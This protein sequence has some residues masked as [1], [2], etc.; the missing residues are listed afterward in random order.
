MQELLG[1]TIEDKAV[2]QMYLWTIDTMG[3]IISINCSKVPEAE[4]ESFKEAQWK[5]NVLPRLM[6]YEQ[7]VKGTS[8]FLGYLSIIDFS[9][10]ELMRYMCMIFPGKHES[11][12]KLN[13]IKEM[14]EKIPQIKEYEESSRA[15]T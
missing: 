7:F 5:N 2:V 12:P 14:I 9:V 6:K 15:V 11:L 4:R 8:W 3:S 13:R 1:K 10:Y